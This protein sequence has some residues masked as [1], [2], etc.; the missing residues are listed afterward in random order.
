M[1]R[2]VRLKH[3]IGPALVALALAAG[4]GDEEPV[5]IEGRALQVRLDEYR[6]IPQ[7]VKVREGRLRIVATN[8][9]RLTHNL[10]VVKQDEDDLEE[11]P[12]ESGGTRSAQPNE[13]EAVTIESLP[14]G[15]Y[16]MSCT[17]ANHDD[18]GQYGALIVEGDGSDR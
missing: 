13:S 4:C 2:P 1:P 5:D 17:I 15:E 16:R 6:V 3:T 9:G 7:N 18:L 8:V 10:K 11:A 12:I 14:P